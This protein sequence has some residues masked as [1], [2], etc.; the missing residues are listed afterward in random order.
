MNFIH[1]MLAER[2]GWINSLVSF[3]GVVTPQV[4]NLKDVLP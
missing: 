2:G 1:D 4:N 3:M